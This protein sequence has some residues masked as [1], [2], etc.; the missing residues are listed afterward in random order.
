MVISL[1]ELLPP[2]FCSAGARGFDCTLLF[3]PRPAD[4]PFPFPEPAAD[5]PLAPAPFCLPRLLETFEMPEI[6][7]R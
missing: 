7:M 4:K 2:E 3:A 1:S 5:L 6:N